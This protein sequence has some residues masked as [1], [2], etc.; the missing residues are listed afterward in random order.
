MPITSENTIEPLYMEIK[1]GYDREKLKYIEDMVL[2]YY[3]T[4]MNTAQ[5]YTLKGKKNC[6]FDRKS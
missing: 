3:L 4:K 1:E 5:C 6:V 2:M